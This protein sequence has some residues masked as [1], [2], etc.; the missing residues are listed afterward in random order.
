MRTLRLALAL[1]VV[2]LFVSA[3]RGRSVRQISSS[4]DPTPPDA[5]GT[6][7]T[8]PVYDPFGGTGGPGSG[9]R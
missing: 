6:R 5:S 8:E 4:L 1:G 9:S 2:L 3:C 7:W